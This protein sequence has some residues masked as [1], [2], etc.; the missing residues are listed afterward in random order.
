MRFGD[1]QLTCRAP[2]LLA[3]AD[4]AI[5]A[6]I[7]HIYNAA[8]TGDSHWSRQQLAFLAGSTGGT[9]KER[10][11]AAGCQVNAVDGRERL[12]IPVAAGAQS[13]NVEVLVVF[14]DRE[15]GFVPADSCRDRQARNGGKR[16]A[17]EKGLVRRAALGRQA[18]QHAARHHPVNRSLAVHGHGRLPVPAAAGAARAGI[19]P[20]GGPGMDLRNQASIVLAHRAH[21]PDVLELDSRG[22][23]K[24]H[25]P[26]LPVTVEDLDLGPAHVGIAH[27][28]PVDD[29]DIPTRANRGVKHFGHRIRV[30]KQV[31]IKLRLKS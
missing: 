14:A 21:V 27:P 30:V 5:G 4:D 7:G 20:H 3:E 26:V 31:L 12:G 9:G 6:G 23:G 29:V 13:G 11:R 18:G 15:G 28:V 19:E 22:K 25:A 10:G 1:L 16:R 24:D 8:G 2:V 17:A